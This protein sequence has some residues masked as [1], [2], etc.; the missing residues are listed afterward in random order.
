MALVTADYAIGA[1]PRFLR[2]EAMR[3]MAAEIESSVPP[4]EPIA[5]LRPGFLPYLYYLRPGLVYLQRIGDLPE[6]VHYLLVRQ[7]DLA[8]TDAALRERH[9]D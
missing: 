1:V 8:P 7:D 9:A 4:G 2:A 5:V 6:P 3:P